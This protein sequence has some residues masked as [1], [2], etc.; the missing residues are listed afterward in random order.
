MSQSFE[1]H[2]DPW[3]I[4]LAFTLPAFPYI[5]NYLQLYADNKNMPFT[6]FNL[7]LS[8]QQ[9][10]FQLLRNCSAGNQ[11]S[12]DIKEKKNLTLGLLCF[13]MLSSKSSDLFQILNYVFLFL[14][15]KQLLDFGQPRV[16]GPCRGNLPNN[17]ISVPY[18]GKEF[19]LGS[20]RNH[21]SG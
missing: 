11:P 18:V 7:P 1:D 10:F 4:F 13:G 12:S 15:L 9:F 21:G 14:Y 17:L 16:P 5:L 6:L 8:A 2:I 3:G 19:L 20:S